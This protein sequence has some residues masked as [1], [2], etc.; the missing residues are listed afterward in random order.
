MKEGEE[1][2]C[3]SLSFIALQE[4]TG[5]GLNDAFAVATAPGSCSGSGKCD[6]DPTG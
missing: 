6:P 1:P 5:S 2:V 3:A 4:L